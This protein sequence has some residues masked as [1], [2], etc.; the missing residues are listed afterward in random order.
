MCGIAGI[1]SVSGT[2][3]RD[4][5]ERVERMTSLLE[6]RGPDGRGV[7]VSPDGSCAI[8]YTRLAISD[9]GN[10]IAQPF[11]ARDGTAVLAF[12]GEIYNDLEVREQLEREGVQFR[13]HMDTEVLLEGLRLHGDDFLHRL[14]GMWAFAYYD[15]SRRRLLLS[16]DVM[17][18]RHCFFAWDRDAGELVFASEVEPILAVLRMPVRWDTEAMVCAV[19]FS[20]APPGRTLLLGVERL[21]PGHHL[22]VAPGVPPTTTRHRM[23]HPERWHDFFAAEPPLE[24][25]I[26]TYEALFARTCARR[27]P[28]DVPYIAT[29]SGGLDTTV[30]CAYASQFG[31]QR[32]TT[33]YGE[34][35]DVPRQQRPDELDEAAASRFTAERL[36]TNHLTTSLRSEA[37]IPVLLR[38]A[39]HGCDGSI[40]LG[41]PSFELLGWKVRAEGKKVILISDGP[42]ELLGGYPSDQRAYRDDRARAAHPLAWRMA[43]CVAGFRGGPRILRAL[44]AGIVHPASESDAFH[45]IPIHHSIS[46]GVLRQFFPAD[47][48]AATDRAYGTIDAAYAAT[49]ATMDDT[50]RRAL[51]YATKSLPDHF[52]LRS[53]KAFLR[54]SVECRLPHQAPA[55]V[56]F[57]IAAPA[58]LRFGKDGATT[59]ALFRAI[60]A[61]RIGPE[62]AYRSKYGFSVPPLRNPIVREAM[63]YGTT[64]AATSLFDEPPFLRS[65]RAQISRPEY[66]KILWPLFVLARTREQLGSR[67]NA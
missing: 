23:L 67:V 62:I 2:P 42:D 7:Y 29:L 40:G 37:A 14:D 63:Q 33:L 64:F 49:A 30:I 9:P 21:L 58:V 35:S 57:M 22:T 4:V 20:A 32:I 48:V 47:L 61:H 13:T 52:N 46:P 11:A 59:K 8:G 53:D 44:G 31:T 34:S 27:L 26:E 16:R 51:S 45:F 50:Q 39:A 25:I 65:A 15:V 12:N 5:R 17:G 28:R 1:I 6:H 55:T 18:E 10:T 41:T 43:Q 38:L 36:R 56:E 54:A 60:V 66:Q 19:R 3:L 24:A